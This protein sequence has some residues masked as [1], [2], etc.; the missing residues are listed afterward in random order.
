MI[1][2]TAVGVF[3][4]MIP[5]KLNGEMTMA[6]AVLENAIMDNVSF[7]PMLITLLSAALA[8]IALF[9]SLFKRDSIKNEYLKGLFQVGPIA[10]C[11]RVAGAAILILCAYKVGPEF[12]WNENTGGFLQS[13]L[14]PALL[15]LFAF[16]LMFISLLLDFGGIELLGGLL[17][18]IFKPLFKLTGSGALMALVSW[19]GSGTTGMILTDKAHKKNELKTRESNL[20][21]YGFAIISL[22]VTFIYSTG[23]GGVEVKYFP[24]ITLTLI[25]C[26]VVTSF[27]LVRIPP[28]SKKPDK[29]FD[30]SE[31]LPVVDDG[32]SAFDKTLDL[33][34]DKARKGPSLF[35]MVKEGLGETFAIAVEVFPM[36]TV[37]ATVVLVLS[38]YTPVFNILASPFTPILQAMGLP[39][40]AKAAPSFFTGFA[41]L[42][43]PF[44]GSAA[45][46]SQLTKFVICVVAI[47]QV[48]CMSEGGVILMKS[49]LDVKFKDLAIVFIVKTVICI[50][51]AYYMGVMFGI[52]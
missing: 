30:G 1:L 7:Y 50:P 22:P 29:Y 3:Y 6:V 4:Y 41:D 20:I 14:I 23:L 42:I 13:Y 24:Y 15:L 21:V 47:M 18:P 26:T 39:E 33:A 49:S 35:A 25:V 17:Q 38:S 48:F 2:A 46:T 11:W 37:V 52:V 36:I 45:V 10:L 51:I 43:L 8:I 28:I 27:I 16:A 9:F 31:T 5:F 34:L 40:A 19:F 12:I 44:L 32:K